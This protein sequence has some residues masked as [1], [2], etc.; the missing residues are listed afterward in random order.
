MNGHSRRKWIPAALACILI[1]GTF[2]PLA[3]LGQGS[4]SSQLTMLIS[5][6]GSARSYAYDTVDYAAASGLA[7][8]G[9]Q[10]L[11]G[12]GDSLMAT[13]QAD[14]QAGTAQAAGIQDAQAA[15]ADYAAASASSSVALSK[16][17]LTAAVDYNAVLSAIAEV[18]ATVEVIASVAAQ[19]CASG[20]ASSSGAQAFAEACAQVAA[21][22]ASAR[23]N[24]TQA[25]S[26]LVQAEG[27]LGASASLSQALSLAA[28]ARADLQASQAALMTISSYTYS[29][30]GQEF[31]ASVVAPLSAEANAT[32]GTEAALIAS[33]TAYQ[34]DWGAYAKSQAEA[35]ANMS[36]SASAV[37]V[38]ISEVNTSAVSTSVTAAQATDTEVRAEMSALLGLVGQTS[39]LAAV[40]ASS[41][42]AIRYDG[43]LN[44]S[45]AW[46]SAFAGANLGAFSGYLSSGVADAAAVQSDGT[47][48]VS[49]Y[50]SV[51]ADL[52]A[53]LTVPG[54]QSIYNVLTGIQVSGSVSGANA[55]LHQETSAMATIQ[56][57]IS[58][59]GTAVSSGGSAVL[60]GTDLLSAAAGVS[61]GGG[62]YLNATAKAT[63]GQVSVDAMSTAQ[64]AQSFVA[65]AQALMQASIGSYSSSATSL[66]AS[67]TSLAT[68]TQSSTNATETA[69]AYLQSDSRVRATEAAVAQAHLTQ[70]LQLFAAQDVTAGAAAMAQ[71]YLGFQEASSAS[72]SA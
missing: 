15:M 37:A 22:V 59:L 38:A 33:V 25:A 17:G 55:A 16:A 31:A 49:A 21:S 7:V 53:Y 54:V 50:R 58:S 47:A 42:A 70:A 39:L 69:L 36:A 9:A 10:A 40:Q 2:T 68:R 26:A 11:L 57:D 19:A 66:A 45:A 48:Y 65:S 13:A 20:S 62:A 24:L 41:S 12:Q 1:A 23:A 60:V 35:S 5:A 51:V 4:A 63:L 30:R 64:A 18:N 43:S 61:S 8:S 6:A 46:S 71:A 44:S 52:A 14:A 67:G 27:H 34:A 29:Q 56:A 28:L 3:V 72:V 32:I